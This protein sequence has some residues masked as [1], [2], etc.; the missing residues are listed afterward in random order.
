MLDEAQAIKNPDS[1]VARAAFALRAHWRLALT[2]TPVENRLEELWSLMH[3]LHPGF[4]GGRRDFAE[5]VARP[6]ALGRDDVA[7]RLRER[8][9]PFMLRR[10][11]QEVAPELPPRTDAVLCVRAERR[12]ARASTRRC[13]PPRARRWWNS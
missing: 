5:R 7:L 8:M 9:R 3:F 1:Q 10:L 11:K 12:G 13:G 6:I 4:L 2:G